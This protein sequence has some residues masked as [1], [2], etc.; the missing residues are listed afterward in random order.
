M[1]VCIF[2]EGYPTK[3]DPQMPFIKNFAVEF[4]KQGN[5]CTI[6]VPQS[7]TRAFKHKL[8]LRK[9]IW[10]DNVDANISITIAQ[11]IYLS[12]S[13]KAVK[14][15]QNR[16]I[17]SAKK[18]YKLISK[19]RSTGFDCL[20]GHFWHMGVIASIIDNK[21]PIFVACGESQISVLQKFS[22]LQIRSLKKQLKGVIYVSSKS[23]DES[24]ELGL[25]TDDLPYLV[26]PNG[27]NSKLFF[28]DNKFECRKKLNWPEDAF[29]V[30]FVGSFTKRKGPDRLAKAIDCLEDN[31]IYS[32]FI[33]A[34]DL[35]PLCRNILY[36]GRVQHDKLRLYLS[37]SDLFVLPTDNEGCCNAIVEAIACGLPII[38][39]NYRFNDDLLNKTNSIRVD[40]YNILELSDA[41]EKIS[42][43]GEL[44]RKMHQSSIQ[45]SKKLTI[46]ERTKRI[47]DFI[48]G[49]IS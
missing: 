36:T 18:G 6:V 23:H 15:N 13:G 21:L 38:S 45:I 29:I 14:F 5:E 43:D 19:K 42:H 35:I 12:L 9:K 10:I 20:Y 17:S 8:P 25:Q 4:S 34:G 24:V 49:H 39:S 27:F 28:C 26:A 3:E 41:I 11:P 40:P 33:G 2:A 1:K 46:E 48:N 32:C 22:E 44:Q 30:V 31:N 37:A 47:I 7:I 16:F